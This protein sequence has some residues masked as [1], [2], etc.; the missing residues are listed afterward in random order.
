MRSTGITLFIV[1][2][3]A[4]AVAQTA[5]K[6]QVQTVPAKYTSPAS[7]Q[8]M[9]DAYCASCHGSKGMG[10]GPA[11][12]AMKAPVPDLTTL[13][14]SHNGEFPALMVTQAIAGDTK[15]AAHGSKDMPVWG[16]VFSHLAQQR[17]GEIQQ[18]LHNLT[19][20]VGSL[21]AK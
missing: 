21:Q 5:K 6:P 18:R 3:A 11:A 10:N 17:N 2:V 20:Y 13:A 16:P 12:P 7:G 4:S 15:V 9:Y 1:M 14:K 19:A 8:E